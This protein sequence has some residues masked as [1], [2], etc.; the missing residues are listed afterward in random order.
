M[1]TFSEHYL[2]CYTP[3]VAEFVSHVE[4]LAHPDIARMPEPFFPA[5][6]SSYERSALRLVI[7]GQDTRGWGDLRKFIQDAKLNPGAKLQS[8]LDE[9]RKHPF[10]DWGGSRHHFWGFAMMMLAALHGRENWVLFRQGAMN[11]LLDSFA[12]GNGN[13][14]ELYES[15]PSKLGIPRGYWNS[16]RSA[17][18]RF[19]KFS[20]IVETLKPHAAVILW[21]RMNPK[22]YFAG[23][24]HQI[25]SRDGRLTHYHLPEVGVDVFHVPHPRSMGYIEGADHFCAKL[26]EL[27][28][29]R[30]IMKPFPEFLAG[31][32]QEQEAMEFLR[33]HAPPAG[34]GFD[35]YAFVSW[36]AEELCKRATFMSVPTLIDLVNAQGYKTN[37]GTE[38]SGGRGSY[39]LVSGTYHRMKANGSPDAEKKAH[40]VAAAFRKPNF[41]Y[42]YNTD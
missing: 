42:A 37:Y 39:N 4:S 25:V 18:A 1:Q 16:I 35:K 3:L 36:V 22:S 12:W 13:A 34:P 33:H 32:S 40:N 10:T 26:K 5:F 20:H 28:S 15:S 11:E 41:E 38:F 17:G 24:T 14:V 2:A 9:F 21:R 31:Q 8:R 19:D 7:I 29:Q 27:F 23:Y 6:G 30:G